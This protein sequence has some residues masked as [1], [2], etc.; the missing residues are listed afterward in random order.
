M[1]V[2]DGQPVNALISNA[3][4]MSRLVDTDTI[5]K[6]D[7]SEASTTSL[8]DVQ[9]VINEALSSLGIANQAA[10]DASAD[11][12][13]SNNV[14]ADSTDRK[15]AIGAL[16]ERFNGTT[17]HNHDGT[18][19]EG[20]QVS[21]ADLANFNNLFAEF[22]EYTFDAASGTSIVVTSLFAS[23]S[24]GGDANTAG[25]ITSAPNNYV[26][27]LEKD[28]GGEIEDAQGDRVY[29]R[30]TE[31]AGVWTLSFFTNEAGTETAHSLSSQDIRFLY[32]EVFTAGTRPTISAN[33]GV[34]DTLSAVGDIPD[35]S[36]SQRGV[37]STGAQ[38][39]GGVKEFDSRPT[40]SG[41]DIVDVSAAQVITGKDID[42]GTASNTN[43]ITLPSDTRANLDGLTRKA[44]TVVYATD[45]Q[46]FLGDN[47]TDLN[48]FGG[49]GGG[50]LD[51]W[52]AEDF[53][54]TDAADFTTGNNA[55][56][57]GAG[58]ATASPADETVSPIAGTRSVSY[59]HVASSLNDYGALPA[60]TLELK[61]EGNTSGYSWYAQYD[62]DDD[63]M[64]FVIYDV[65]TAAV[66]QE[67]NIK[68]STQPLRY[69]T[70]QFHASTST[71]IR[72]GYQVKVENIGSKLVLDDIQA[73]LDPF[74]F[75]NVQENQFIHL[76]THAG[77]GSTATAIPYFTNE[78]ANTGASIL[79]LNNDS[80]DGAY[81]EALKEC[82][83]TG[84]WSFD[85][86]VAGSNQGWTLNPSDVTQSVQ[87]VSAADRL[88]LGQPGSAGDSNTHAVTVRLAVG[89][90]LYPHGGGTA[91]SVAARCHLV[92][93]AISEVENVITPIGPEKQQ[94]R[95]RQANGYGSTNTFVRK[96]STNIE[97]VGTA[98]TYTSS[99]TD[100]DSWTI[101]EPGEYF[102]TWNDNFS[103][104]T[105]MGILKNSSN[106]TSAF[107]T[108]DNLLAT[109]ATNAATAAEVS[110]S[111]YLDAG[112]II[113]CQ[114]DAATGGGGAGGRF[115]ISKLNIAPLAATLVP[116]T[117]ILT[118][119]LS[120]GT[121]AGA[122]VAASY[123][124]VRNLNTSRGDTEI[125]SLSSNQFTL[126]SGK[127]YIEF[128]AP[129]FAVDDHQ[130]KLYNV[131]DA[132]DEF[133]GQNAYASNAAPETGSTS[134]GKG[135]VDIN[136]S[137]TYEIRHYTNT[138]KASNGLG[139]AITTGSN[140]VYTQV[141]I[142]KVR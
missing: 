92:I 79:T 14:V 86:N 136:T 103:S 131:T 1:A 104:G 95:V 8:V 61:Q 4:W 85:S 56:F 142:T 118:E 130:A 93:T 83:V 33:V 49:G 128:E 77:Y 139:T 32:R 22:G 62:G 27:I 96:F 129:G 76:D 58:A 17:G 113:R 11:D 111:G 43:R 90:R 51:V 13:S 59:T 18:D 9:R 127:Y 71:D 74:V 65:A 5:G 91:A 36:A 115:T 121:N 21:A 37:V 98:V 105:G 19:G 68:A 72:V 97:E 106:L 47:G 122:N 114:V 75:K 45:E 84:V 53:E 15:V 141:T 82:V 46:K 63:D 38:T 12:Y 50:G 30:L 16:D 54:T 3:A 132:A 55:T 81:V 41:N 28:T 64:V 2:S 112:D 66:L 126:A 78:R 23:Q 108:N 39:F 135:T 88:S 26:S 137:K 10:T 117:A 6:I 60:Q 140:E 52:Y 89:D 69:E 70:S 48:E 24:A 116:L 7:L 40:T 73:S 100:G 99:G 102:C 110:W 25:V 94:S 119:E 35:A 34:Y 80:T 42:G 87:D 133:L 138:L 101:N 57:L 67:I 120:S 123:T 109:G 125:V 20:A 29:S 44:G 134:I 31:A 107:E 124:Q